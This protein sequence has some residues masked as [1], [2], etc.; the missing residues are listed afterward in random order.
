V[1]GVPGRERVVELVQQ[2]LGLAGVLSGD[3]GQVG[4]DPQAEGYGGGELRGEALG[5][6]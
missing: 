5:V 4:V 6:P 3:G 2:M 1:S